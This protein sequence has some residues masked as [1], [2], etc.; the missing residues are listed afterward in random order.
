MKTDSEKTT[1]K[2]NVKKIIGFSFLAVI[3]IIL[4]VVYNNFNKLL[5]QALLRSFNSSIVSD[6][7]ELKFEDLRVNIF[8]RTIKVFNVTML[9]R[10]KPLN[11]YPYINSSF[12]LKT[13]KLTLKNVEILPYWN[14]VNS[15]WKESPSQI[16]QLNYCLAGNKASSSPLKIQRPS[17]SQ[18]GR[19]KR[20]LSNHFC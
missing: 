16:Q 13:E 1:Q 19:L 3:A 17:H 7:Y 10:E 20:N 9:P 15:S 18:Q 2:S 11:T 6:V 5:S 4:I 8:D 12:R 14:K